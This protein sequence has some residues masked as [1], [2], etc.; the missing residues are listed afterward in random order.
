MP[1]DPHIAGRKLAAIAAIEDC[2]IEEAFDRVTDLYIAIQNG[3]WNKG[4]TLGVVDSNGD[5]CGT[6]SVTSEPN[7]PDEN[8]EID[9]D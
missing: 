4:L 9:L 6:V 1:F 3:V 2:T 8:F 7:E 5:L